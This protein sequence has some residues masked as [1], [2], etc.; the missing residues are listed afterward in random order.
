[1]KTFFAVSAVLLAIVAAGSAPASAQ[2]A[3]FKSQVA[4]D[5]GDLKIG[6]ASGAAI[7][8]KDGKFDASAAVTDI[9]RIGSN[10]LVA[11]PQAGVSLPAGAIGAFGMLTR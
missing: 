3:Y 1:M 8:F 5:A 2:S 4:L 10:S 6:H 7:D 11:A 9:V